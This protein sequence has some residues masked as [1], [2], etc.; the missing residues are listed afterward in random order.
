MPSRQAARFWE[1]AGHQGVSKTL[2]CL[3][4]PEVIGHLRG[5][6]RNSA[7]DQHGGAWNCFQSQCAAHFLC[8][9]G[10]QKWYGWHRRRCLEECGDGVSRLGWTISA[11]HFLIGASTNKPFHFG[12]LE[13]PSSRP[14][15][16][17]LAAGAKCHAAHWASRDWCRDV[18]G[19]ACAVAGWR[20][21]GSAST[22]HGNPSTGNK[23]ELAASGTWGILPS[24]CWCL[25]LPMLIFVPMVRFCKGFFLD[26][27]HRIQQPIDTN[28]VSLNKHLWASYSI[29]KR[30]FF[31]L[32]VQNTDSTFRTWLIK[33]WPRQL[34]GWPR[35]PPCRFWSWTTCCRVCVEKVLTC[36]T[37]TMYGR[38]FLENN[39][40][41]GAFCTVHTFQ[42]WYDKYSNQ[43]C[44][45]L[46]L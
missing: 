13:V 7:V 30:L 4:C 28:Y 38:R 1:R 40:S 42:S 24:G 12:T 5:R 26:N 36:L 37:A 35:T 23:G 46:M 20:R 2:R 43:T 32:G 25:G 14:C 8:A 19:M 18:E 21:H 6:E 41:G 34:Q 16:R 39:R 44:V 10:L 33:S 22:Q 15:S 29:S 11:T 3:W 9:T 45:A 27:P 17:I 31:C